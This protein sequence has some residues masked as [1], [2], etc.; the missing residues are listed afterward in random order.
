MIFKDRF[1]SRD[2]RLRRSGT[3]RRMRLRS[4]EFAKSAT[5]KC[6]LSPRIVAGTQSL[7][8]ALK[9]NLSADYHYRFNKMSSNFRLKCALCH[10]Y[11]SRQDLAT[12]HF[13]KDH[14]TAEFTP[15]VDTMWALSNVNIV[16]HFLSG[17]LML[18]SCLCQWWTVASRKRYTTGSG[19]MASRRRWKARRAA[20]LDSQH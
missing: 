9:R 16:Y 14:P 11:F 20:H 13:K 1:Y 10:K 17:L 6:P 3:S 19:K 5:G 15:F 8:W 18:R 2:P 12:G 4:E 7:I